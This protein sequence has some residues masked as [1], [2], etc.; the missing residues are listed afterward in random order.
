MIMYCSKSSNSYGHQKLK[1]ADDLQMK[2]AVS[3]DCSL[4]TGATEFTVRK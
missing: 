3:G 4:G 2:T 1:V